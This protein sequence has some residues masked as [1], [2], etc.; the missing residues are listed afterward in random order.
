MIFY[1]KVNVYFNNT[2][3]S[4]TMYEAVLELAKN[5]VLGGGGGCT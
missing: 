1:K 2:V 5:I 3:F 4:H